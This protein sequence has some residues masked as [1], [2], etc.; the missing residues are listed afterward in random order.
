MF[1]RYAVCAQQLAAE[2][3]HLAY[4]L[5]EASGRVEIL[6]DDDNLPNTAVSSS[7]ASDPVQNGIWPPAPVLKV[8]Q[9]AQVTA[10]FTK[11]KL[12]G[13]AVGKTV[14]Y[15]L[16][17]GMGFGVFVYGVGALFG[18]VLGPLGGLPLGFV[19][20][21]LLRA[22]YYPMTPDKVPALRRC[23]RAAG[24]IGAPAFC[25]GIPLAVMLICE[26]IPAGLGPVSLDSFFLPA[27]VLGLASLAGF[28]AGTQ[29]ANWYCAAW[30]VKP[31][32]VKVEAR[33]KIR[34]E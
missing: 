17:Y 19:L 29:F 16:V 5:S 14:S 22:N 1:T 32:A 8:I 15:G 21:R 25:G 11:Q 6:M 20:G 9:P 13:L 2:I 12:I 18:A 3:A 31:S 4:C 30:G 24:A 33:S 27:I 28:L 23:M 10:P 34:G 7:P 26:S